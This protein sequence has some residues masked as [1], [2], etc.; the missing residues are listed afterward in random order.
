MF[1]IGYSGKWNWA[2]AKCWRQLFC[3]ASH[4]ITCGCCILL[5]LETVCLP[6]DVF[7]LLE[8]PGSISSGCNALSL[9]VLEGCVCFSVSVSAHECV[10]F[11]FSQCEKSAGGFTWPWGLWLQ[12]NSHLV[13]YAIICCSL[14]GKNKGS[15]IP[16]CFQTLGVYCLNA[17]FHIKSSYGFYLTNF[18]C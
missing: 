2:T 7:S 6:Q 15:L 1:L 14:C 4:R 16:L 17:N 11:S 18:Y 9:A 5:R 13:N 10:C 3:S 12:S 8:P